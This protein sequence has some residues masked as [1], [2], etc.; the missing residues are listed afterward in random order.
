MIQVLISCTCSAAD[1]FLSKD[2][3]ASAEM[4]EKSML[5]VPYDME[6]RVVRAKGYRVLCLCHLRLSQLDQALEY[7]N[8]AEK[9]FLVILAIL[10]VFKTNSILQVNHVSLW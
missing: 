1:L 7:I 9:V 8:E 5:Y 10:L 2:Y 3:K 4:F 6:N